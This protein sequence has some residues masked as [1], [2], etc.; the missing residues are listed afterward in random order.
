MRDKR[1]FQ[2]I[3]LIYYL[4]VFNRDTDQLVGHVVDIGVNGIKLMTKEPVKEGIIFR[5]RMLLPSQM[6]DKSR[7]ICFNAKCVWSKE[8]LY[9][10][11][12]GSGYQF[13]D[14][15]TEDIDILKD[16]IEQFGYQK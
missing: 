1:E 5:F 16:L 11:F 2:R 14:I 8:K 3:H 6:E 4:L 7:E 10:D 13:Q 12:Y 9:S 15:S